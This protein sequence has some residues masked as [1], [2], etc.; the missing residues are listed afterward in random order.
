MDTRS[1][2]ANVD[3][4]EKLDLL[5]SG[6]IFSAHYVKAVYYNN[7]HIQESATVQCWYNQI[8]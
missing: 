8:C 1:C 3:A 6:H 4:P 7:K 5:T 2:C